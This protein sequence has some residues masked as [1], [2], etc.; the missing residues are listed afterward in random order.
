MA[1][2]IL[3]SRGKTNGLIEDMNNAISAAVAAVNDDRIVFVKYVLPELLLRTE[4][5]TSVHS[6][7]STLSVQARL[8]TYNHCS[9]NHWFL[10][11]SSTFAFAFY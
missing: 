6:W 4:I 5:T 7:E 1:D 8:E 10:S 9:H 3:R 2:L 11:L